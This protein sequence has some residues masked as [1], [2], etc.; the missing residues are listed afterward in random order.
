MVNVQTDACYG[1]A[2]APFNG[3]WRYLNFPMGSRILADMHINHKEVLAVVMAAENWSSLWANK[4]I[5]IHSDNQ[6]AVTIINKG[7]TKNPIVMHY[8]RRLFWYFA[9]FNF[10]ITA[11]YIPVKEMPL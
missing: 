4:H 10:R 8:L 3:D 1:V 9:I 2:G 7:M 6:T 5:I 11:K